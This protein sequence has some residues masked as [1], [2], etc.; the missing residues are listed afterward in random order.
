MGCDIRESPYFDALVQAM[1]H[2]IGR[3]TA[4]GL[5]AAFGLSDVHVIH[6]L[7][8]EACGCIWCEP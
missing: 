8:L 2:H 3:E 6:A 7:C 5:R 1:T 4:I